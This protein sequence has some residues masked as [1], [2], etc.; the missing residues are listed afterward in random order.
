MK[1]KFILAGMT[2]S[3]LA[4]S[5]GSLAYADVS[6]NGAAVHTRIFN[7]CPTS[8]VTVDN[9]YPGHITIGDADLSCFGYANLHN[10]RFSSDG[11]ATDAVFNNGDSFRFSADLVVSGSGDAESGFQ[12]SPWWSHDVDGRLNVR[13]TDGEIAAFGGRLPFYSFTASQGLHYVKGTSLGLEIAYHPNGLSE[14][15]PPT[16]EYIV[17]YGGSEYTSGPLAFD[18]GNP[19]EGYG[20]WGMLNDARVGG[21]LQVFL[22]PGTSSNATATWSSIVYNP[23]PTAT[24][25]STWGNL[26]GL[27]R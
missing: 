27:Y 20:S 14:S 5:L 4:L 11:G 2:L 3:V 6:V 1:K 21:H 9:S 13:T 17:R 8:T 7:D 22:T 19:A 25:P 23:G 18:E 16:I 26:K 10:W 12:V 24:E 15:R